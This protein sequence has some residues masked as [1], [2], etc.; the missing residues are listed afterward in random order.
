[1]ISDDS[2]ASKKGEKYEGINSDQSLTTSDDIAIGEIKTTPIKI[3]DE[4]NLNDFK[5]DNV[6]KIK[7][8]SSVNSTN[9]EDK[10]IL[11]KQKHLNESCVHYKYGR[12]ASKS[13]ANPASDISEKNVGDKSDDTILKLEGSSEVS[14]TGSGTLSNIFGE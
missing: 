6:S 5:T 12:M 11:L 13:Y 3:E 2:K 7:K 8:L 10:E 14:Q 9:H 1:M 4:E